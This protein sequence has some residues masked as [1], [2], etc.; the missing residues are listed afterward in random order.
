MLAARVIP[1]VIRLLCVVRPR[2]AISVGAPDNT[3]VESLR[4]TVMLVNAPACIG[5]QADKLIPVSSMTARTPQGPPFTPHSPFVS[6][7]IDRI[8]C[9]AFHLAQCSHSQRRATRVHA[10]RYRLTILRGR[11]SGAASLSSGRLTE[12]RARCHI[13]VLC[14]IMAAQLTVLRYDRIQSQ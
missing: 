11:S 1:R 5:F 14:P 8:P 4:Q 6:V 12:S 10:G 7:T 9:V 2:L 3:C 13:G